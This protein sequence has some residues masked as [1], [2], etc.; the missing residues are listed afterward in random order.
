MLRQTAIV[1]LALVMNAA[2]LAQDLGAGEPVAAP[3]IMILGTFHFTGGGSDYVNSPVV[4]YLSETR[5]LEIAAVLD[6]L[7][8]F[9]SFHGP[10]FYR[11]PRNTGRM[12]LERIDWIAPDRDGEGA[13]SLEVFW[14]GEPL[15]YR[16]VEAD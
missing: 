4:N 12:R 6:R 2:A 16:I 11:L 8:A 3:E 5:Q 9:A 14:A 13:E 1:L 7:E 15:R 10:D